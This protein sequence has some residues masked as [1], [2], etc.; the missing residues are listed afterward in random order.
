MGRECFSRIEYTT[1]AKGMSTE[2]DKE[3]KQKINQ[4]ATPT[5]PN[6]SH[7]QISKEYNKRKPQTTPNPRASEYMKKNTVRDEA[8]LSSC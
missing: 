8:P 4:T 6:N 7:K 2:N 1:K 5:Q 3:N